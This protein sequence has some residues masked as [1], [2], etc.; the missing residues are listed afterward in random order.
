MSRACA[1]HDGT[2]IE[3]DESYGPI[4]VNP[5]ERRFV[6]RGFATGAAKALGL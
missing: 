2:A 4:C 6:V 5:K 3:L 1:M